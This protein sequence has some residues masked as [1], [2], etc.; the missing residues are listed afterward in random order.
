M[1]GSY[2]SR[3]VD[4]STALSSQ[5][6]VSIIGV[7]VDV[8]GGVWKSRG[9]SSCITFTIKDSGLD[10]GHT[11]DGLKIKYFKDNES[12]LPPVQVRDVILLRNLTVKPFKGDPL[13]VAAHYDDVPWAIF[14]LDP[15][16]MSSPA[17][18]C[19][20]SDFEPSSSEKIHAL[21]LLNSAAAVN[22]FRKA[23]AYDV[24]RGPN[25]VQA[26]I[27]NPK[28]WDQKRLTLIK[29]IEER[30]FVSL[31]GE[32]VKIYTN[33]SEKVLLHLT[34]Y[35]INESLQ[36]HQL[37]DGGDEGYGAE[38]DI[39]GY[40][41]R[42]KKK[43]T[44]PTGR[45]SLPITLW[46]PHASYAR[47]HLKANDLIQLSNV[48]VKRSRINGILE[49]S[50]HTNRT[51]PNLVNVHTVDH[52]KD[53]HAE[54]FIQRKTEYWK[55]N[56]R[57]REAES[58]NQQPPKKSAKKQRKKFQK[59]E[60]GQVPIT[61][62]NSK[63]YA[64]NEN[65]KAGNPSVPTM[66]LEAI[67]SNKFHDNTS[68]DKIEYR[69]PFQ[70][71]CYRTTV[72]VVDFFPPRLEDFSVPED[73]SDDETGPGDPNRF[74]RWEWRFCILVE[75]VPPP[76][77]GQAKEQMRLFVAGPNAEYLL[78]LTAVDL[79]RN[80]HDLKDLR[81]KLFIIWG[82]LE[83]RKRMALHDGKQDLGPVSCRPFSCCVQEYGVLCSHRPD[84]ESTNNEDDE[85]GCSHDD[86]FGWDRRFAMFLTTIA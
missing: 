34:D 76:P 29:D 77:A 73:A 4:V 33:D 52:R 26:A 84:T 32:I 64:P 10:N 8:F 24:P 14:R 55:S 16:P 63:R 85:N 7:V 78:G 27:S 30:T 41:K 31:L 6:K 40:Q 38:G 80:P 22:G 82:D 65:I 36:D 81:E 58:E 69:L 23:P 17:P 71:F 48:H 46:E 2:S 47:Q 11:W 42:P 20:P 60:E 37:D 75:S 74:I 61:T 59:V 1:S 72:R 83:E 19:G 15:D 66:S 25:V 62:A 50:V 12:H 21:N 56:P 68:Y 35:T 44:G 70:N 51:N 79:R 67:L 49:A 13:G 18:L 54:E 53:A 45:M 39:Y 28:P 9:S 57:K 5:G 43:W 3:F 86:C